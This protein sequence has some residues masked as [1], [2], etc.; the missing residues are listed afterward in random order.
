MGSEVLGT[1]LAGKLDDSYKHV[2]FVNITRGNST[3][4]TIHCLGSGCY[5]TSL[6]VNAGMCG[7]AFLAAAWLT[8]RHTNGTA[9]TTFGKKFRSV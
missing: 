2:S 1:L 9:N 3:A 6:L 8:Y 4:G 5:H 7:A